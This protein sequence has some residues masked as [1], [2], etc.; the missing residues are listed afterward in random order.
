M[1]KGIVVDVMDWVILSSMI[2][3]VVF[4]ASAAVL[5][6]MD[7]RTERSTERADAHII[8]HPGSNQEASAA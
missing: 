8:R 4:F 5:E 6:W 2:A 7:A 3:L 1:R